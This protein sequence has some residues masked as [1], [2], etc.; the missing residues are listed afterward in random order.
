MRP[1]DAVVYCNA[2]LGCGG[3]V[4]IRKRRSMNDLLSVRSYWLSSPIKLRYQ[5][6][7]QA[8]VRG[9]F[10]FLL[11]PCLHVSWSKLGSPSVYIPLL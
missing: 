6:D 2:V 7:I 1:R 9:A 3:N 5:P 4:F 8:T 10:F 11:S